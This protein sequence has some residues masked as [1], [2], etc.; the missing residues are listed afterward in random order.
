MVIVTCPS[1]LSRIANPGIRQL[2]TLRLQQLSPPASPAT[3]FEFIVV[4][5]GDAVTEIEQA[6]GFPI[7]ASLFDNLPFNHPDFCPCHELLEEHRYEHYGIYEMVFNCNDDGAAT[8]LFIPDQ[9]GID[10]NLLAMC[11][12]WATPALSTP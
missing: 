6:A 11:R 7:L 3:P 9:E 2:V 10:A 5:G 4:E 12:S 8:A 1:D